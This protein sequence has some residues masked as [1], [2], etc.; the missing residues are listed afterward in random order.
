MATPQSIDALCQ[1]ARQAIAERDWDKARQAYLQALGLK[2][3]SP[4]IHQGLA[5]VCFQ[6]RDLH[7]AAHHFKEVT[8][9]DPLRAGAFINLGAVCNLLD[10][11]DEAIAALRRG[12]QLDS[13]RSEGYY[14]LGLVYRRKGQIDLAIHAYRE[15]LRLNPRMADACYNL[16]NLHLDKEQFAQAIQCYKQALQIRPGWE[17]ALQG[18]TNA[19]QALEAASGV[20]EVTQQ[21]AAPAAEKPAPVTARIDPHRM[22]DPDLHGVLLNALHKATIESENHGRAFHQLVCDEIEPVIKELSSC[23]ISPDISISVLDACIE[24]FEGALVHMR[25]T[26][27]NLQNSVRK[28]QALGEKLVTDTR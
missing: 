20:E 10:Q 22:V 3:D 24:K 28:V 1:Q 23:L 7:S 5:T 14:N 8:R 9:L 13:Q 27:D 15:A 21:E 6:L 17:K 16:G 26:R 2:S 12:I 18:L 4:D 25:S 11:L 19:Q